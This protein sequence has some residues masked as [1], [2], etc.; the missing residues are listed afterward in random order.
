MSTISYTI[1]LEPAEE[2]GFS[3]SVPALPGCYT[4]GATFEE[5]IAMAEDA[6]KLWLEELTDAGE[7]IP[8]DH[9]GAGL[10]MARIEVAAPMLS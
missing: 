5:A 6:V 9:A 7:P 4:Q 8:N 1:V 3:V 10:R 2:G